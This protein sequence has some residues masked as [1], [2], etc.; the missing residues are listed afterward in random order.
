MNVQSF[1]LIL[2]SVLQ[3][4]FQLILL[5]LIGIIS[6]KLKDIGSDIKER[7]KIFRKQYNRIFVNSYNESHLLDILDKFSI[8]ATKNSLAGISNDFSNYIG[9]IPPENR[10][11]YI[12]ALLGVILIKVKNPPHKWEVSRLEFESILQEQSSLYVISGSAPLPNEYADAVVPAEQISALEQKKFIAAIRE[13]QYDK[14]IPEAMTDYWKADLTIA[15]YFKNNLMYLVSL[16]LYMNDLS[17]KMNYSKNDFDLDAEGA[18]YEE[19]IKLSK[20]FYNKVMSWDAVD[21]GSIIRNQG[22]FQRG[23]I[24][25]I[26]DETD[27]FWKVGDVTDEHK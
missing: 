1:F 2:Y 6:I 12:G 13:I 7:E 25:N 4:L 19:Q 9:H 10:D 24:H 23:V 21:F 3:L 11:R 8:E 5:F 14:M 20:K 27:F 17:A 15:Q 16:D 18:S 22:Y 26:V